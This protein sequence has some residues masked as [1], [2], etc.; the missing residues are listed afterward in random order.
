MV[1]I[2]TRRVLLD[3]VKNL[4]LSLVALVVLLLLG[5]VIRWG[6]KVADGGISFP[7]LARLTTTLAPYSLSIAL[8]PACLMAGLLTFGRMA[9]EGETEALMCS[10]VPLARLLR[11]LGPLALLASVLSVFL[12][13]EAVTWAANER[14]MLIASAR[15][16]QLPLL[17][18]PAS[19]KLAEIVPALRIDFTSREGDTLYGVKILRLREGGTPDLI[20]A[21]RARYEL[22]RADRRMDL[23]LDDGVVEM[24]QALPAEE[25][26]YDRMA[27]GSYTLTATLPPDWRARSAGRRE[28]YMSLLELEAAKEEAAQAEEEAGGGVGPASDEAEAHESAIEFEIQRKLAWGAASGV[29]LLFGAVLGLRARPRRAQAALPLVVLVF[30]SYYLFMV[31]VQGASDSLGAYA[32][33]AVWTP[34]A[35]VLALAGWLWARKPV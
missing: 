5:N 34:D 22:N 21:A 9:A 12:Q 15:I 6:L 29:F 30:T 10:G 19:R 14:R 24:G 35:S 18:G 1:R 27:F 26:R 31:S 25:S 7:F 23:F 4:A 32:P 28:K 3:L 33:A 17:V 20:L 16:E 2:L 8:A 11:P 13:S